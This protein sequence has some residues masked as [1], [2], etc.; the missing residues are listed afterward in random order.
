LTTHTIGTGEEPLP[1]AAIGIPQWLSL[2]TAPTFAIMA[3]VTGVHGGGPRDVLCAAAQHASPLTGMVGMYL[4]M[5]VFHSA[6]W[7]KLICS[8]RLSDRR[9]NR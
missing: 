9:N 6:P 8:R 3:L 2:A 4:L 7:L 1:V 5:S